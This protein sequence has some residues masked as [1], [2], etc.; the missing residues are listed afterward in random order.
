MSDDWIIVSEDTPLEE[1]LAIDVDGNFC[2]GIVEENHAEES[3][4]GFACYN[5]DCWLDNIIAY[6]SLPYLYLPDVYDRW[7]NERRKIKQD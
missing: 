4:T 6:T 7:K 2:V 1:A 3:K 5:D